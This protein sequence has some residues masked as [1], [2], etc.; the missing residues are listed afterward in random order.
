[1]LELKTVYWNSPASYTS[2]QPKPLQNTGPKTNSIG[3]RGA[4][5]YH[6]SGR[7]GSGAICWGLYSTCSFCALERRHIE[8]FFGLDWWLSF[9]AVTRSSYH[10]FPHSVHRLC[11]V[12][13]RFFPH[14]W[15][16]WGKHQPPSTT[17][18]PVHVCPWV[19]S[20]VCH[21]PWIRFSV[22]S[23]ACPC[24]YGYVT[25]S[26]VLCPY[27]LP[28]VRSRMLSRAQPVAHSPH[29]AQQ[30]APFSFVSAGPVQPSFVSFVSA[31]SVQSSYVSWVSAD[32]VQLRSSRAPSSARSSR[33]HPGL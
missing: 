17:V 6:L 11:V 29:R 13:G 26:R 9:L 21:N 15:W 10:M 2:L 4:S 5:L 16:G 33:T 30:G 18:T 19:C 20:R 1:M 32:P 7:S 28:R 31:G 27:P 8:D 14:S 3:G 12:A 23:S 25:P 24:T 22:I